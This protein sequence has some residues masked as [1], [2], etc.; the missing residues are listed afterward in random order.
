MGRRS[1]SYPGGGGGNCTR[2]PIS[3]TFCPNCGYGMPPE[4]WPE[5]GREHE[6]LRELVGVW[7]G[8]SP[9][10]RQKIIKLVRGG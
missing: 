8:L 6:A 1:R 5:H 9:Q 3:T 10:V 2:V 4:G 7:H